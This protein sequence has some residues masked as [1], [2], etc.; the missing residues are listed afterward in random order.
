MRVLTVNSGPFPRYHRGSCVCERYDLRITRRC[1]VADLGFEASVAF[2]DCRTHPI[3]HAFEHQRS[4]D[5]V[6]TRTVGPAAGD[7]TIYRLG[8]GHDHRGATW[9]DPDEQ[10]VWLCAYGLHRSGEPDDAFPYFHEL[11]ETGAILPTED[12]YA[13]LFEDRGHRFAD[14]VHDDAQ[15]LLELARSTP[16]LEQVGTVGGEETTGVLVDVVDTLEE[17]YVAFSIERMDSERLIVI[18]TAFYVDAEFSEWELV[19]NLPKRPLR[20]N[21]VCYRILRG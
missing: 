13:A 9:H 21:E 17:T 1:L 8:H 10:V 7:R 5:P 2:A 14:T 11:I 12:D 16:G 20:R 4:A 6:G 18:L 3:V 15:R 19:S